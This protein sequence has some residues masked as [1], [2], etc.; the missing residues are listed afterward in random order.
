MV[1]AMDDDLGFAHVLADAADEITRA[2]YVPGGTMEYGIKH[3]GT[4][5]S[6]TDHAV[7]QALLALVRRH[8][9]GDAFLGEE[10]GEHGTGRRRWVVDG[11]DGTSSFVNG[12]PLWGT[13]I[14]LV[15]D[16][17]P[18]LGM[19]SSPAQGRRWWATRGSGTWTKPHDRA[20]PASSVP[21]KVAGLL[22][23]RRPRANVELVGE[24]HGTR[25]IVDRLVGRIEPVAMTAHPGLMVAAGEIDLA[26]QVTGGPWDFAAVMIMVLEAGGR[27]LDL[28]GA[29]VGVPQPPM[30]Y[31]GAIDPE[32]L[33]RLLDG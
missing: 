25:P 18:A 3:D 28:Q 16:E 2:S 19:N 11:I 22:E 23:G 29:D 32:H 17:A 6:E 30:V 20:D 14:A 24:R 12:D 8:R 4:P 26:V 7:E 10:V 27:C 5:V 9:P 33:R 21:L 31:T 1:E 15:H 13:L